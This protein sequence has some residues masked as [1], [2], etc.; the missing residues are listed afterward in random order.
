MREVHITKDCIIY[1]DME[2]GWVSGKNQ[3][4]WHRSL[5]DRWK[6]MWKRCKDPNNDRYDDYKDCPI[7]DKYQYLS[8]YINDIQLLEDFDLLKENPSQYE[9]DKDR[10]DS[11]NRCYYFEHL[12]IIL[13]TENT[14]ERN[15]RLGNPNPSIPIIGININDNTFLLFKSP[16]DALDKGF[17]PSNIRKCCKGIY[18]KSKSLYKGYFLELFRYK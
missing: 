2:W 11:N 12:S 4:R 1:N 8:N 6:N 9:I 16:Y 17:D 18:C 7:D 3:P 5:Y 15:T 10:I 13:S 14:K